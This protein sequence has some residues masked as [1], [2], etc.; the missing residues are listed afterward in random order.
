ME[1]YAASKISFFKKGDKRVVNIDDKYAHKI[2]ED[3]NTITYGFSANADIFPLEYSFNTEGIKMELSVF[4]KTLHIESKLIGKYN[5]YNIMCAVGVAS[6]FGKDANEIEQGIKNCK[7]VPGR[8][9]FF[10]Y[11]DKY[12]VVDYAHTDDAMV[13]VL[14]TL[15]DIK[16]NRL[17]VVFGAGGDRDVTKRPKMG[18][19]ADRLA[20]IVFVTSDN[21]RSEKIETIISDILSGIKRRDNIFTEVERKKA[22]LRALDMAQ[23]NDIVAVL[24]KGHEDYQILNDKTIHFDDREVIKEHWNI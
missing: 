11:K 10:K 16:K 4:G 9:E 23:K 18:A 14:N 6:Y 19:A 3:G 15:N 12:A 5:I 24:G 22:I 8:L 1:R 21:P 2:I 20:D 17:I 13:N 7:T